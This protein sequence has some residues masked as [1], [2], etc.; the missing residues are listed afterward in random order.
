MLLHGTTL[1]GQVCDQLSEQV[2]NLLRKRT[3]ARQM[4]GRYRVNA[5]RTD[6]RYELLWHFCGDISTLLQ[7]TTT[8]T[9]L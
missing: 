1:S 3:S 5:N 9:R 6:S 2:F 4:S 7:S 8:S